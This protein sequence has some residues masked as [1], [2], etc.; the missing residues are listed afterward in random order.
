MLIYILKLSACLFL[1]IGF[2]KLVLE[3]ESFH[4]IKRFYLLFA[5]ALSISIPLIT[6]TNYVE[7]TPVIASTS[8]ITAVPEIAYQQK[9]IGIS[10]TD[11]LPKIL[12]SLYS[13]GVLIFSLRFTKHLNQLYFRIQTNPKLKD[14]NFTN[15]LLSQTVNPHTFF[16]FIFFNK[17]KFENN[18]IPKEVLLHE[19]THAKQ[20]HALDILIV[21]VLQ[22]IFWFHPL[23]YL[24]KKDIKLNHEFLADQAVLQ[25]GAEPSSYQQLLLT[26]SSPDG[27]RDAKT[28]QL[29]NAINYSSIKKRL[30]VMKTHTSNT[31][32]WIKNL[33]LLPLLAVLIFSFSS[34]KVEYISASQNNTVI[35]PPIELYLDS[36]GT[37]YHNNL[38]IK[39]EDLATIQPLEND[40]NVSIETSLETDEEVTKTV[41]KSI[42]EYLRQQGLKGFSICVNA[43]AELNQKSATRAQMAEYTKLATYYNK[44]LNKKNITIYMKDVERLKHL[45]NLMSEKQRK[46][47]EPFPDFPEP[48]PVPK[49]PKTMSAEEVAPPPP[50]I[51][52]NA[53][54]EETRKYKEVIANYKRNAELEKNYKETEIKEAIKQ[55]AA[56]KEK[57]RISA[58]KTPKSPIAQDVKTYF[59]N[60]NGK[61]LYVTNINNKLTYYNRYGVKTDEKGNE[62]DAGKQTNASDVIPGSHIVKV[63]DNDEVVSEFNNNRSL[64]PPP[65]PPEIPSMLELANSGAVFYFEGKEIS[66]KKAVALTDANKDLNIL[67]KGI[68]SKKPIVKLSKEPIAVSKQKRKKRSN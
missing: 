3:R 35:N 25:K 1:F 62:L 27:Y 2:Y 5:L 61:K 58:P 52:E 10:W 36:N 44:N 37:L 46:N 8:E 47:A 7:V 60:V 20:L 32:T 48:P 34:E 55:L 40:M 13:I 67:I 39:I 18:L 33:L 30:T 14:Q 15:V 50:P 66:G 54:R 12:W 11:H 6:F 28:H 64:I 59:I 57:S 19:Q 16:K 29:A 38:E 4:K 65:P 53:T 42:R 41:S 23:L 24:I 49:A 45:Y 68:D 63:F 9:A 43:L 17:V 22:I 26:F 56:Q 51:P 31:K 21:E